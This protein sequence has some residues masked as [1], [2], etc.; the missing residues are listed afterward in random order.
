M[1]NAFAMVADQLNVGRDALVAVVDIGATMTTLS[2]LRNQRTI[3]SREQVFG[4]KQLTDE[5]MR[6][7][8]LSYEE[9][10]R[11]KRKGGLPDSYESEA[12]EPFKESLIQQIGRLLQFFFAGSEYSKVDQVVLAGGCASIEGIGPMLEDQLGV[13]CVVANPLARMSLSPRVQ[14]QSLAQD[15]P[16]LMIAG[17]PRTEELRLMATYQPTSVARRAPQAART[18][19]LHAAGR[20]PRGGDTGAHAVVILDGRAHRQPERPQHLFAR[21]RSSSSTS[22]S[23][24]SRI[25]RRCVS[26]CW[27]ASR[28]SSSCR[29]T[30]RRWCICST[31]WSGLFR[32]ARAW[33]GLKQTGDS[34]TLDGVAQSN[35]S[36]AEYMRNIEASPWMGHADLRKTENTHA[37]D[38]R[39]PY[40]FGLDVTLSRPK[41]DESGDVA[42]DDQAPILPSAKPAAAAGAA[43]TPPAPAPAAAAQPSK[44]AAATSVSSGAKPTSPAGNGGAKS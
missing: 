31:S 4:G 17:R 2:V 15:A 28:S 44:P 29:P 42:D 41:S 19:V 38:T 23:S 14:A 35:A 21:L 12:L 25:W 20:C 43:A 40:N 24:R 36:V 30:A 9:A 22:A 39:M 37:G 18:R 32:P 3:Y 7:Y 26:D 27:R 16:A 33:A 10:G 11:A 5:I 1:E 13:P 6:R 8:G 34:L